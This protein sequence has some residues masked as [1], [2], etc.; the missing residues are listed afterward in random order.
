APPPK[1]DD[2]PSTAASNHPSPA[3][4]TN[5]QHRSSTRGDH[6]KVGPAPTI[7][8]VAMSLSARLHSRVVAVLPCYLLLLVQACGSAGE[9]GMAGGGGR[10]R[11]T[12]TSS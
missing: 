8:V 6:D 10:A 9:N 4:F 5:L 3:R 11:D 7:G 12:G 2:R 1:I